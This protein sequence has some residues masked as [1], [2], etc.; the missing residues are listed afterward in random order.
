[1]ITMDNAGSSYDEKRVVRE[2]K[3][4]REKERAY[5]AQPVP[6]GATACECGCRKVGDCWSLHSFKMNMPKDVS[7]T[8]RERKILEYTK[9]KKK[10]RTGR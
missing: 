2:F 5:L 6:V 9:W 1:M 10:M 3:E 8:D 4:Q 7:G